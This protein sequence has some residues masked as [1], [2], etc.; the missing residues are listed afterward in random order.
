MVLVDYAPKHQNFGKRGSK[1]LRHK[2][3]QDLQL[4]NSGITIDGL[5]RSSHRKRKS[6]GSVVNS[7]G[8]EVRFLRQHQ[9]NLLRDEVFH[10]QPYSYLVAAQRRCVLFASTHATLGDQQDRSSQHKDRASDVEDGSTDAAG[11]GQS[12]TRIIVDLDT[13]LSAIRSTLEDIIASRILG[14]LVAN[15]ETTS[16]F[17]ILF[18]LCACGCNV[19]ALFYHGTNIEDKNACIPQ[20]TQAFVVAIGV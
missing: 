11:R 18:I 17:Q 8:I 2:A 9:G 12:G 5:C 4:A 15:G 16:G 14:G 20:V 7:P 3:F 19:S 10:R 6:P 1:P 13:E